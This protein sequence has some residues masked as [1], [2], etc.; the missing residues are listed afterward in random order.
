MDIEMDLDVDTLPLAIVPF[1]RWFSGRLTG[2]WFDHHGF[3]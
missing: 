3:F 1:R 2:G